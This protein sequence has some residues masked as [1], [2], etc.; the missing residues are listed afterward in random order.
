MLGYEDKPISWY[1]MM[2]PRLK[3]YYEDLKARDPLNAEK[4]AVK[5]DFDGVRAYLVAKGAKC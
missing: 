5:R 1:K 4:S 2:F 3:V